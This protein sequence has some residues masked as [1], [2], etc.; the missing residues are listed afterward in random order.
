[1]KPTS[2]FPWP[3]RPVDFVDE[4]VV[5]EFSPVCPDPAF[6]SDLKQRLL[7]AHPQMSER[8]NLWRTLT[9]D[10]L[11]IWSMV[12]TLPVILGIAAFLWRR[13][14]RTVEQPA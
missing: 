2:R 12:A 5:G 7:A 14:Q 3:N 10:P 9:A 6:R 11:R 4:V 13:S 1:M 8:R